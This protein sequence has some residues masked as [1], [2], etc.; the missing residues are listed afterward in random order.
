MLIDKSYESET[1]LRRVNNVSYK[2][3]KPKLKKT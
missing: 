3:T 2:V 1:V